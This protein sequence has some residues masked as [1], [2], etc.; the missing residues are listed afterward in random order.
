[1]GGFTSFEEWAAADPKGY[2]QANTAQTSGK[3]KIGY[4]S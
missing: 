2:E 1:M 3:I 4:G